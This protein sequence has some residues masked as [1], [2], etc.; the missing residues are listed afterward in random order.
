MEST[1]SGGRSPK[2]TSLFEKYSPRYSPNAS[3]VSF[4]QSYGHTNGFSHTEEP[5]RAAPYEHANGMATNGIRGQS[6]R[7][8]S[9]SRS[10]I[11]REFPQA[12][13]LSSIYPDYD[14]FAYSADVDKLLLPRFTGLGRSGAG[15]YEQSGRP[16]NGHVEQ[17]NVG[18]L[19]AGPSVSG[20]DQSLVREGKGLFGNHR[21]GSDWTDGRLKHDYDT[22][23]TDSRRSDGTSNSIHKAGSK[24][25]FLYLTTAGV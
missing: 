24:F 19:G 11:D 6:A 20:G 4:S 23:D 22:I 9:S 12:D 14:P 2:G 18:L 21:Q 16:Q 13:R 8:F 3:S 7:P 25:V 5:R 15:S 1:S 17:G 10:S